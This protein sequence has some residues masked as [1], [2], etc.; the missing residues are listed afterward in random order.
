MSITLNLA[1]RSPS[2]ASPAEDCKLE[3]LLCLASTYQSAKRDFPQVIHAKHSWAI[4]HVVLLTERSLH[5][6][7]K[8][9]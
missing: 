5:R 6:P 3:W 7:R 8:A 9:S 1:S 4:H 2:K